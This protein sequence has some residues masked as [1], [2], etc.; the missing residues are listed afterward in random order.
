MFKVV[1]TII[2]LN[3]HFLEKS[4]SATNIP[5]GGIF[6][7]PDQ[8]QLVAFTAAV[9]R[10]NKKG[11]FKNYILKAVPVYIEPEIIIDG[12]KK[13]IV[14]INWSLPYIA[15]EVACNM[16]QKGVVGIFTSLSDSSDDI[17]QSV[18]DTK[19]IPVI[20][21]NSI[22]D[23]T[24]ECCSINLYPQLAIVLQAF[25]DIVHY[26]KWDNFAILFETINMDA[27]S[28]ILK[29]SNSTGV[30]VNLYQLEKK[31]LSGF[32]DSLKEIRDSGITNIVLH[33][34]TENLN[35]ILK[36]AQ[37][38]GMVMKNYNYIVLNFDM[39]TIDLSS[40]Q[41]SET[42]ITGLQL[43]DPTS[44]SV[45]KASEQIQRTRKK[46][47][48][49][50]ES[51]HLAAWK[52]K[53]STSLL[54]DAVMV[55]AETL[56]D[57]ENFNVTQLSCNSTN[58]WKYGSTVTNYIKMKTIDGLTGLI[59][60]DH[61]GVRNDFRLNVISLKE[62]GLIKIGTWTP[63]NKVQITKNAVISLEDEAN[64]LKNKHLNVMIIWSE[65]YAFF[66]NSTSALV[67]NDQFEGFVVDL[68]YEI[69]KLEGF[70]YTLIRNEDDKNGDYDPV[71]KTWSGMIGDVLSGRGDIAIGDMA[72]TSEREEYV[73]FTTP[74]MSLG[75]QILYLRPTKSEPVFFSFAHPFEIEVWL[76]IAVS[77]LGVSIGL[78]MMA[79]VCQREWDTWDKCIKNPKYLLN[80]F[81]MSNSL[82]FVW[83]CFMQQGAEIAPKAAS[84]RILSS[85]FAFFILVIVSF[86]KAQ[87]AAFL[88]TEKLVMPFN[89]AE[90]L[91]KRSEKLKIAYG[92]VANEATHKFFQRSQDS[93]FKK[94]GAYMDAHPE[95][96][97]EDTYEGSLKVLQ[98]NYAF[99]MES[100][101]IKYIAN[102]VCEFTSVGERL[103][104]RYFAIALKKNS[105][106]RTSLSSAIL[107]LQQ[108]GVIDTLE[109]K[110]WE[111]SLGSS[112]CKE[113]EPDPVAPPLTLRHMAG[114]FWITI[115]G[116]FLAFLLSFV[117]LAMHVLK[118]TG[119]DV[120]AFLIQYK[121][122]VKLAFT[123]SKKEKDV[124][125]E[126]LILHD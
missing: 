98:G 47:K 104:E 36:Q 99:F 110:W 13:S 54:I 121:K 67:G 26:W 63:D 84:T 29:F 78:Y 125:S 70:N 20:K 85:F 58:S 65:P 92:A 44:S 87:L 109:R 57:I 117:E 55:L 46:L 27:I 102:A 62:G 32:R 91:I 97:A 12:L 9:D 49:K 107:E 23:T 95:Y 16:L 61:R 21:V 45:I 69:S 82:W 22:K 113:P 53:T 50:T 80:Q 43:V 7:G 37:E 42:N 86:Y 14:G 114:M 28:E 4:L 115:C 5:I 48:M 40:Y 72:V 100:V 34:T 89:N 105:P 119:H 25:N 8:D 56:K 52:L 77:Y 17:V 11:L 106:Y 1:I 126:N 124:Q 83:G 81:H 88:T 39:H 93:V 19:E 41:H 31:S 6:E 74:F 96:M 10:V 60:F 108:K 111:E 35:D 90:E 18:C 116:V 38:V 68:I 122:E 33:C 76:W 2:I 79:R 75:I 15:M 123:F 73:D 103:D 30:V 51:P 24:K 120:K 112:L 59:R 3:T 71:T 94:I 66:K 101:T 118:Q 64:S